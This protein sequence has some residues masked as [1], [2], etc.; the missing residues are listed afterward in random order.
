MSEM[1]T[2]RPDLRDKG[3]TPAPRRP[4]RR[5]PDCGAD[6]RHRTRVLDG[7]EAARWYRPRRADHRHQHGLPGARKTT[8]GPARHYG[9]T[10]RWRWPSSK[11]WWPPAAGVPVTLKMRTGWCAAEKNAPGIARAAEAAGIAL[12]TVQHG[13]TREQATAARPNTTPSPRSRP[14]AHSRGGLTAI[15]TAPRRRAPCCA[16]IG[17]DRSDG[18]AA[19]GRPWIFRDRHFLA[20]PAST[21]PRRW[22]PRCAAPCSST[23]RSTTPSMAS[24]PVRARRASNIIGGKRLFGA[25]VFRQ[26]ML[27]LDNRQLNTPWP[28]TSTG[29]PSG[30][31]A[32]QPAA[33]AAAQPEPLPGRMSNS[34]DACIR[35]N[36]ASYFRDLATLSPARSNDMVVIPRSGRCRRRDA[37]HRQQPVARRA[38]ARAQP[39]HAAQEAARARPPL[40]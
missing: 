15:S 40:E 11:P 34:I 28:T 24:T 14:A 31:R 23:C 26:R 21:S 13:R 16:T 2:S 12:L 27:T 4:H 18:R 25:E 19:Q 30:D 6:R 3:K 37:A 20:A 22:W 1:I 17:V 29:W 7:P 33:A 38:V 10:R 8:N 39:Q 35:A 5:G 36:L 32:V 9:V